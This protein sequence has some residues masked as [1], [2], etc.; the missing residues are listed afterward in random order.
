MVALSFLPWI[1]HGNGSTL[2]LVR[3]GEVIASGVTGSAVPAVLGA[4][5]ILVPLAGAMCV[6][7]SGIAGTLSRVALR[8]SSAAAATMV[9]G[10]H[11]LLWWHNRPL[12][13]AAITAAGLVVLLAV[14]AWLPPR[15]R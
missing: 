2:S 4:C 14:A 1:R 13:L 5:V 6:I 12:G 3:T 8:V 9:A 10:T 7:A 11:V 15:W